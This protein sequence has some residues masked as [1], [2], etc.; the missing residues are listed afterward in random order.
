MITAANVPEPIPSPD[1]G[2]NAD[3]GDETV[4]DEGDKADDGDDAAD[5]GDDDSTPTPAPE[6]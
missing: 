3:D 4:P 2:D 5:N 6:P 1:G